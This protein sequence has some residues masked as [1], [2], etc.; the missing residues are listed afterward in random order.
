MGAVKSIFMEYEEQYRA[1]KSQAKPLDDNTLDGGVQQA[2]QEPFN[3]EQFEKDFDNW[4]DAIEA[5]QIGDSE[6][7]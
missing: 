6:Y 7:E 3:Q 1:K 5:Q 2:Q 4:L